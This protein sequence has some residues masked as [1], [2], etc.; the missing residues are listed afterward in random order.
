MRAA[1]LQDRTLPEALAALTRETAQEGIEID[2]RYVPASEFPILSPR[3]EAGV[4]RIAQE[5]L[6]NAYKHAQAQHISLTLVVEN[7]DLCLYVQDDGCG[8]FPDEVTQAT[9]SL[10]G[11]KVEH[12]GLTGM[13]ER[14]KL[15]GGTLSISSEPGAGTYVVACIPLD[16]R[17]GKR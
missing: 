3:L 9:S 16:E 4:Y 10:S 15:L 11:S 7:G 8:F 5:A 13:S 1:S 6:S 2:Y 14:V 17:R 12:F